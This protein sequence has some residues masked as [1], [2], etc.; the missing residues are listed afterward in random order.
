MLMDSLFTKLC[1]PNAICNVVVV[2][3]LL[4]LW[5]CVSHS[6]L[7]TYTVSLRNGWERKLFSGDG[8]GRFIITICNGIGWGKQSVTQQCTLVRIKNY[9]YMYYTQEVGWWWK[10]RCDD[11]MRWDCVSKERDKEQKTIRRE[12]F[13]FQSVSEVEWGRTWP[14]GTTNRSLHWETIIRK[15]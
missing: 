7:L 12:T 3:W 2:D 1:S 8:R 10:I 9:G 11:E 13:Q 4:L 15:F 14:S 6:S 5:L